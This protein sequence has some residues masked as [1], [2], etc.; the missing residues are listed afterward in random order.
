MSLEE[1]IAHE[2]LEAYGGLPE[3]AAL[4]DRVDA[5]LLAERVLGLKVEFCR[6]SPGGDILGLT[7]PG[8]VCLLLPGADG[9]LH[10]R[11]LDGATVLLEERLRL[12][13]TAPGRLAFTL[14]H[15]VGHQ[16]LCLRAPSLARE[17]RRADALAALL[18]MPEALLRRNLRRAGIPGGLTRLNP[19]LDPE[20]CRRFRAVAARM[21][22]SQAALARRMRALGLLA[23]DE[24]R[25]PGAALDIF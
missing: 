3:A 18:L 12:P 25:D 7:A 22:V 21:G 11:A 4:P 8:P 1:D 10:A 23:A 15:E 13:G 17:E 20:G 16:L 5:F 24:R 6:L 14:M 2:V 9:L 19:L